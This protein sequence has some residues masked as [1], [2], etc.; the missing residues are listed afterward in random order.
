[1]QVTSRMR[2]EDLDNIYSSLVRCVF[3][4]QDSYDKT[5]LI[6]VNIQNKFSSE[7]LCVFTTVSTVARELVF[8]RGAE[9]ALLLSAWNQAF[10]PP[11]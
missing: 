9:A 10:S 8:S 5:E 3:R 2:V 6:Q 7:T 4:Y 1:M 11:V